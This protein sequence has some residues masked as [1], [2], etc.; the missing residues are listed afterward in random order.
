M[1]SNEVAEHSGQR[2]LQRASAHLA[3]TLRNARQSLGLS[4][5]QVAFRAGIAVVT[6]SNLERGIS[7]SGTPANPTLRTLLR[8]FEVLGIQFV[9]GR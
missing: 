4:Q 1:Q 6:L 5:E 9:A 7:S 8:I 2:E 3:T